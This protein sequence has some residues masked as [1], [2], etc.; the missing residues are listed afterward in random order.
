M[1]PL[2]NIAIHSANIAGKFII[3]YYNNY[4]FI[5]NT[6]NKNKK[7][8]NKIKNETTKLIINTIHKFYPKHII[9]HEKDTIIKTKKIKNK[10]YWILNPI[11]GK[12]N[13]IKN[14]LYF[15]ISIFVYINN[16]IEIS[17]IYEP[18]CNELFTCIR[19]RGAQ[20]NGYRIRTSEKHNLQEANL[21]INLCLQET[22]FTQ[23]IN[24]I[25]KLFYT[26]YAI[27]FRCIGSTIL[28]LAYTASGKIDV[29]FQ[30][31]SNPIKYLGPILLIQESGGIVTDF[32]GN[33]NYLI[34]GKIIAGN[35][36]IV[37]SILNIINKN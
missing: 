5:K 25:K 15:T 2:L 34:S 9:L 20:L 11:N 26:K 7:S 1:H 33:K 8:F 19:G 6:K 18:I 32:S 13:F 22:Y 37:E 16:K 35:P 10:I 27:E 4:S 17:V 28:E 36:Y 31:V 29:F 3:K 30:Q 12:Q 23:Y 24:I 14:F 21:A